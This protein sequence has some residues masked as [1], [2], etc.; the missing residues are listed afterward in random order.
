MPGMRSGLRVQGTADRNPSGTSGERTRFPAH[1]APTGHL[2][3][4][5]PMR[6]GERKDGG[7]MR[8][9]PVVPPTVAGK[10]ILVG[11]PNV[12]KSVIFGHLTGRYVTVSNYPG[13][14]VEVSGGKTRERGKSLEVIATPG[15]YSLL[16]MSEDERVTRDILMREPGS[17]VLQVCDAKNMRRSLLITIQLAGRGG[18][19]VL[20]GNRAA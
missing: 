1:D 20:D 7:P 8:K 9:S 6:A 18:P 12:G 17:V 19:L 4:L 13:T 5:P 10:V 3:I 16:P 11:N 14:T 2:R 15:G